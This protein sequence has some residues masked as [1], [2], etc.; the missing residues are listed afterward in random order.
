MNR[1]LAS[2]ATGSQIAVALLLAL[3]GVRFALV[4]FTSLFAAEDPSKVADAGPGA[5]SAFQEMLGD[6]KRKVT[7]SQREAADKVLPS[8]PASKP[9]HDN[10]NTAPSKT[11]AG[12]EGAAQQVMLNVS[13]GP[14][15]S[16]LYVNGRRLGKTPYVGNYS[17]R[18]GA[19]LQVQ[20]LPE[21]GPIIE[22]ETQCKGHDINIR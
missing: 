5:N 10:A 7:S 1:W 12:R 16:D 11:P 6:A 15:R 2:L 19:T 13:A 18:A 22:L 17:C 21:V 3:L 4:A 8:K 20:I 9:A 14:A